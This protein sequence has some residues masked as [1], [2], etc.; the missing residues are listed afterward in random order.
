LDKLVGLAMLVAATVV[1]LYYT[2]WTLLMVCFAAT[3]V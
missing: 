3:S 1:F 2:I